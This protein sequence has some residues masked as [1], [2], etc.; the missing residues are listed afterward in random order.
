[1]IILEMNLN[2]IERVLK[3]CIDYYNNYEEYYCTEEKA[4]KRLE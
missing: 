4:R 3:L 2:D 1:M